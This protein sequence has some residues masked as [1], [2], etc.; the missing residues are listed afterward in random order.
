MAAA[1][2][3]ASRQIARRLLAL[4]LLSLPFLRHAAFR[5]AFTIGWQKA[6]DYFTFRYA[7][8]TPPLH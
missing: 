7:I 3:A 8:D 4:P 1:I 6:A 5:R 2:F